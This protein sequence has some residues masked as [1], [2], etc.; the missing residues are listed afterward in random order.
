MTDPLDPVRAVLGAPEDVDL[1]P[2]VA[3]RAPVPGDDGPG[4]DPGPGGEDDGQW[5]P[6]YGPDGDLPPPPGV[7]PTD[8]DLLR[9]A[10][11]FEQ[12][13]LGNARRFVLHFGSD[14]IHIPG[15][16]WHVWD[17]MRWRKDAFRIAVRSRAQ[18]LS[19]LVLEEV[20]F[21]QLGPG[22]MARIADAPA[23]KKAVARLEAARLAEGKAFAGQADLDAA[24]ARLDAAQA[25]QAKLSAFRGSHAKFARSTGNRDKIAAALT[26]AEVPLT[27]RL[28]DMDVAP[29]DLNTEAGVLRFTVTRAD[30]ASPVA[31]VQLVPHDRAQR[32]TKVAACGYDPDATAPTFR[33]F[34]DRIQPDKTMQGFLQRWFGYSALG[35]TGEQALAF[36]YGDGAN[37]KSVLVDL[38]ARVLGDYSATAKIESLTGESKRGGNEATPDLIPL[39]NARLVR[40]SEPEKGVQW[41]EGLIKQ[42]TGGEPILVREHYQPFIEITPKFKLTISGNDKPDIR[43]TDDGIWRRFMI[44]PFKV[45]IP[46]AERRPKAEIDEA[47]FAEAPGVLN[48][49]VQGILDYLEAG[50]AP[51]SEVV[52]ATDELR[53]ESDPYGEFLDEACI[54]TGDPG[55]SLTSRQ[56][57]LAFTFWQMQKAVTPYKEG[58]I[59]RAMKDHSRRWRSPRT[60]RSFTARQG[61]GWNGYD[62]LRLTDIFRRQFD[63]AQKDKDGRPLSVP[64]DPAPGAR[65]G[66][67]DNS[68]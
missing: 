37:G 66:E 9:E 11:G 58:T 63:S 32:N 53:R 40:S 27:V 30:G 57:M 12:N 35:L 26:E 24:E 1:P 31:D 2:D 33:A 39:T 13:D 65:G 6:D 67:W 22:E 19:R 42:L 4:G 20:A 7:E 28:D 41:K 36:F 55:D 54:V 49:I 48:W 45:Q 10:A 44:V 3:A 18:K 60:G 68:F 51:P 59:S 15:V 25:A 50:L 21:V 38:I 62:G 46:K 64:D 23:A 5:E 8:P 17:G 47:L 43:G 56:L 16:G 14:V 61:N 29:L 34:L 52:T